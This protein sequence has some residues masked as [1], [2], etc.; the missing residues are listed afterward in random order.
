MPFDLDH[1]KNP[2][3][4]IASEFQNN[5]FGYLNHAYKVAGEIL[6][7]VDLKPTHMRT[8]SLLDYGCGTGRISMA[9]SHAFNRVVGYDPVPECIAVAHSDKQRSIGR[10]VTMNNLSFHS[11]FTELDGKTFDVIV[12]VSVLE[13][14]TLADQIIALRNIHSAMGES[15]LAI[16]WLH[17]VKNSSLCNLLGA[18]KHPDNGIVVVNVNKP[19]IS[20]CLDNLSAV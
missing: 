18:P 8:M 11:N 14:L 13:H 1:W 10:T 12:S 15:S 9:L 20:K 17:S 3:K 5:D 6:R 7:F 16:L 19:Q 2:R 4:T